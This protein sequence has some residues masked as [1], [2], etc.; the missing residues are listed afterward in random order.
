MSPASPA[1]VSPDTCPHELRP[2][3]TV[4]LRCR[5]EA[6]RASRARLRRTLARLVAVAV[7]LGGISA[8]VVRFRPRPG[9]TTL[10]ATGALPVDSAADSSAAQGA[11]A[12]TTAARV[13]EAGGQVGTTSGGEVDAAAAATP[14]PSRSDSV[15]RS[16]GARTSVTGPASIIPEGRTELGEG[17]FAVRQGGTVT[18]TFDTPS[19]RTR[20]RDKFERVLRETLPR[21]FGAVGDSALHRNQISDLLGDLDLVTEIA[22][23]GLRL[24]IPDGRTLAIWPGT[25]P[26]RDG[27]LVVSYRAILH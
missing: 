12:I 21:V 18:V 8:L 14:S 23:R 15:A 2:G 13:R 17:V 5:R 20:R 27:P 22:P 24:S 6:R 26:G 19:T 7:V 11:G 25:R 16:E 10:V 3:T 9:E 1:P 4:C